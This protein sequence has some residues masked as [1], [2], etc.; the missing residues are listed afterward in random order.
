MKILFGLMLLAVACWQVVT[1][2][3]PVAG[4]TAV[5]FDGYGVFFVVVLAVMGIA[6]LAGLI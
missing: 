2:R 4:Q 3:R 5:V 6:L 1:L